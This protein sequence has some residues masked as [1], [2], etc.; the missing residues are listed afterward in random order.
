MTEL[1]IMQRAKQYIDAL[2]NGFDPLSGAPVKE[3]D[4]INQVRISR[5]L[6]YVSGVLQKV[7]DNGGEIKKQKIPRPKK[8]LFAI[9]AEQTAQLKPYT[10][11]VSATR[12]VAVINS[13][14]DT[15]TM[16]KLKT[17]D[18]TG[19]LLS[20]EMLTEVEDSQGKKRKI[21]TAN[22]ESIGMKETSFVNEQGIP[23]K[24][25]IYNQNAQQFIL[26]NLEAII[27]FIHEQEQQDAVVHP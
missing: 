14:I 10:S 23:Q 26:D 16:Q 8:A 24:Y 12:I 18:V 3:D 7:I 22:G 17:T 6:F 13:I 11:D 20:I 27:A 2:A 19:W 1:E 25:T 15:D 4:V 9:S 5:C 21:P